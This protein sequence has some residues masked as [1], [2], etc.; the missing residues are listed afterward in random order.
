MFDQDRQQEFAELLG[1]CQSRVMACIYALLHNI[2]DTEDVYQQAC[3]VMWR[4]FDTYQPGTQFVKWACRVAYLEVM[5]YLRRQDKGAPF[6]DS[7]NN[8][9]TIWMDDLVSTDDGDRRVHALHL[10]MERLTDNDRY[11]L[12][13]RYWQP[14]TVADIAAELG[15][16]PQSICN[17]LS[18][19]RAEL[20][21]CVER[22]LVAE[23]RT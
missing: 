12:D 23:D 18:R 9:F 4:K 22:T 1:A 17:S 14:K 16:T 5:A 21:E 20:L 11:L 8:E 7:F 10:C 19:I 13:L 6:S 15:R 3:L 2:H